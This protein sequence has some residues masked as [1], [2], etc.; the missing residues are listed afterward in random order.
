MPFERMRLA[1]AAALVLF[2]ASTQAVVRGGV[3]VIP[4]PDGATRAR[5]QDRPVLVVEQPKP[6]AIIGI[7]LDAVVGPHVLVVELAERGRTEIPFK[8]TDKAYPVQ[9]I[10]LADDKMVNPPPDELA[11]IE[12]EA[13]LQNEQY[14]RFSPVA[15]SPFPMRLPAVGPVSS[16]FGLRRIL[17]GQPRNPHAGLDI[18]APTGAPVMAPAAG[19]ISF[20]G[21]L[22]FNGNAIFVDHGGGLISMV[23]HLSKIEVQQGNAVRKGQRIGLVGATGRATGPHLHWSVSLNGARVDPSAVLALYQPKPKPKPAKPSQ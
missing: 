22:Y 8:V 18:A 21:P 3:Q 11:R 20:A 19:T 15:A 10:T 13:I 23:C 6:T 5:Y 12:R 14:D 17:N 1:A 7:A 2:S 9:R 16:N 4:L